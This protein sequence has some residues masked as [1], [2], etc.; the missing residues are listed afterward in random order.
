M[1][2]AIGCVAVALR[3]DRAFIA[4]ESFLVFVFNLLMNVIT[5]MRKTSS[6]AS[7]KINQTLIHS[8]FSNTLKPGESLY[9]KKTA[10]TNVGEI[11]SAGI[12]SFKGNEI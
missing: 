2:D 4:P 7:V 5:E 6:S 1:M 9:V 3:R 11:D 8:Y 10:E 12:S